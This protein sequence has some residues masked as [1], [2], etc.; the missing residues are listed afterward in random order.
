[1]SDVGPKRI[2][3]LS[4]D[5]TNK[6][7]AGEIIQR[8]ANAVKELLDNC[9]DAGA[10]SITVTVAEGGLKLLQIQDDGCGIH[11]EDLHILCTRHTT[12]KLEKFDD[13]GKLETLG[14]RGEALASLSYVS[15]LSV[16]T[17]RKA[18]DHA[19]RAKFDSSHIQGDATP[20]AGVDGTIV[21]VEDL[22]YNV[23]MRKKTLKNAAEE[24][25]HLLDVVQRYAVYHAGIS[26]TLRRTKTTKTDVH[27]QRGMSR[28]EAIRHVYGIGSNSILSFERST[29]DGETA[30]KIIVSGML[31]GPGFTS[32]KKTK[33][34]LFVNGR[35]VESPVLRRCVESVYGVLLPKGV[36]PFVFLSIRMPPE[37]VDVNLHPTKAE[38]AMLHEEA[39]CDCVR[40]GVEESLL[41]TEDTRSMEKNV[42]V[43]TLLPPSRTTDTVDMAQATD[44]TDGTKGQGR[45]SGRSRRPERLVRVDAQSRTLDELLLSAP[46]RKNR[47]RP[48]G[49]FDVGSTWDVHEGLREILRENVVI[50]WVDSEHILVQKATKLYLLDVGELSH[51]LFAQM[52]SQPANVRGNRVTLRPPPSVSELLLIALSSQADD[53]SERDDRSINEEVSGLLCDLLCKHAEW[54]EATFGIVVSTGGKRLIQLPDLG[55][56]EKCAPLDASRLPDFLLRLAA[57]V[58][59]T[60]EGARRRGVADSLSDLYRLREGDEEERSDAVWMAVKSSLVPQR[61]RATDGSVVELTR[62][63]QLYRTFERC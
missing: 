11:H 17:K 29:S 59:W 53:T 43:Q 58:E 41:A 57:E 2:Q 44:A 55:L 32:A 5:V 20:C 21:T 31:T 47:R 22:F 36:K 6:I 7:A 16:T 18:D 63:E 13:L 12:S 39:V 50:G 49:A 23:P 24:Y 19:W 48:S 28:L 15:L 35:C 37:W 40:S 27:T 14:F 45:A 33:L 1:M 61:Q 60:D 4:S 54:L 38:V 56:G 9:I 52:L 26:F 51:D 42:R 10:G 30:G 62:L 25:N 46:C 8:P 3:P 34:L